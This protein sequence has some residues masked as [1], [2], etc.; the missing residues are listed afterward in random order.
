MRVHLGSFEFHVDVVIQ[1]RF[2]R[3]Q[4]GVLTTKLQPQ[5]ID[6]NKRRYFNKFLNLTV[7]EGSTVGNNLELQ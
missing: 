3:P 6:D 1:A 7:L 5:H 4:R 2:A